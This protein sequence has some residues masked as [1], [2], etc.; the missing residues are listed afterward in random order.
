M[1]KTRDLNP[2]SESP[3]K[4]LYKRKANFKGIDHLKRMYSF[5]EDVKDND[6]QYLA[7]TSYRKQGT[8]YKMKSDPKEMLKESPQREEID[9][10]IF[11]TFDS[12]DQKRIV[13]DRKMMINYVSHGIK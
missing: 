9:T 6:T 2:S 10:K 4:H 12:R 1:N 5:V 11:N 3:M 8:K 13:Q 7:N